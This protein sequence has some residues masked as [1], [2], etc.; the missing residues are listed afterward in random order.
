MAP[1]LATLKRLKVEYYRLQFL[2][3]SILLAGFELMFKT[4]N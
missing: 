3:F 1:I 2:S 4:R